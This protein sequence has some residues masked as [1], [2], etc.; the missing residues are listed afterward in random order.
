M[1][2][3]TFTETIRAFK[4][5]TPFRPFTVVTVSGNRHEV[6]HPDTLAVNDGLAMLAGRFWMIVPALAIAGIL[7][8]KKRVQPSPGTLP[9]T[10]PLFAVLLV[11]VIVV[12]GALTFLPALS[13]GPIVEHFAMRGQTT[14]FVQVSAASDHE[15]PGQHARPWQVRASGPMQLGEGCLQHILGKRR[16]ARQAQQVAI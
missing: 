10:G 8:G 7:A 9:T 1:D 3:E 4:N 2:Q 6:D 5:R 13:L 16:V 14:T 15:G 11:A 12:V